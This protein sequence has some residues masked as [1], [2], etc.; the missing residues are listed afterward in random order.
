MVLDA[1]RSVL[2]SKFFPFFT[3]LITVGCYYLSWDMLTIWYM[4]LCGMAMLLLLKDLTPMLSLF[5]FMNI[6]ISMNNSPSYSAGNSD[7]YFR[8]P[9][10]A[11]IGV[12]LGL[13]ML[14][15]ILRL[16]WGIKQGNLR[17]TPLLFGFA[18]FSVSLIFNGIFSPAYVPLD[19]AYGAFLAFC[20]VVIFMLF[21]C[22]I[23]VTRDT[24]E[25]I[26]WA[27]FV[28][29]IALVLEL[30]VKYLISGA[31]TEN[32]I[33]RSKI[34]F[35][36][37]V[38]NTMGMLLCI[39]IPFIAYLAG[40]YRHGWLFTV[41]L[42]V[43]TA[44]TF[45]SMSRQ[46][47]VGGAF[48]FIVS[49]VLLF[50]KGQHKKINAAIYVVVILAF[51]IALFVRREAVVHVINM[52]LDNFMFG[53][54]RASLWEKGLNAFLSAPLFGTGFYVEGL[55]E[56]ISIVGLDIIP[57]MYHNTIVQLLACGGLLAFCTYVV[58]RTQTV[59]CYFKNPTVE[60]TYLVF[61]VATLLVVNLFD[62]HLFYILPTLVYSF[63]IAVLANSEHTIA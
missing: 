38:Y 55:T 36:W 57:L 49:S 37:G 18:A 47:M 1:L 40:K 33:D 31:V 46:A 6:M 12:L 16:A 63:L 35:G 61:T 13:Y 23:K 9:V 60:R 5:L 41:W 42:L 20:F 14:V 19:A 29:S 43:V 50:A 59:I 54:G 58:H 2:S 24:F 3:A 25:H 15:A 56:A 62:N 21:A 28:F 17:R 10:I 51:C 7:F 30:F 11:Q 34:M 48:A 26:A 52:L 27:F 53:S 45:M 44:A 39:C 4:A 8:T 32:G 22:N